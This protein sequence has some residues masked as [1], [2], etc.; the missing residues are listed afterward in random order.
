MRTEV[1]VSAVLT[2]N[3]LQLIFLSA[4]S[5]ELSSDE[6]PGIFRYLWQAMFSQLVQCWFG[7]NSNYSETGDRT[8]SQNRKLKVCGLI[9]NVH[10]LLL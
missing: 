2:P 8:F 4:N 3:E 9:F 10:S 5:Q 1:A 7:S 6:R